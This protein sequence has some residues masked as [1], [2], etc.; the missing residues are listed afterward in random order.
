MAVPVSIPKLGNRMRAGLVAEWY[1]PDGAVVHSGD[2]VCRLECDFVT[3]DLEAEGSGVLRHRLDAGL[4]R[5]PGDLLGV[6]LAQGERLPDFEPVD[7]EAFL[8]EPEPETPP[9]DG[10]APAPV[11]AAHGGRW[12]SP[13]AAM[14]TDWEAPA[15]EPADVEPAFV[16][17][18]E[19]EPSAEPALTDPL[20]FPRRPHFELRP[21][22]TGL[23]D[24]VPGDA[25]EFES[26]LLPVPRDAIL[27]SHVEPQSMVHDAEDSESMDLADWLKREPENPAPLLDA[28]ASNPIAPGWTR[29]DAGEDAA[30]PVAP[31]AAALTMSATVA[32]T[33]AHKMC[34]QLAREWRAAEI[35]P[36]ADDIVLRAVARAL[37][38]LPALAHEAPLALRTLH[39]GEDAIRVL[40]NAA[41]RPF[42]DAVATLASGGDTGAP[43]AVLTSCAADGIEAATPRL[44][45]GHPLALALG[46]ERQAP[47]WN[48]EHWLPG[49]V[50][51]LTIAY[52]PAAIADAEAARFLARVR[53]LVESPYALLAD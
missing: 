42:R 35:R 22:T 19:P 25:A 27:E 12:N 23:W 1:Q 46:A 20:P 44:D 39:D 18:P 14:P 36:A 43:I 4:V 37:R 38:D 24:P 17:E 2:P 7:L 5:P 3:V 40:A 28:P 33:E 16:P 52:D 41:T 29:W 49:P 8:P 34:E 48:G 32:L 21:Q 26:E 50:S 6:I 53:D 30:A 31:A 9:A 11:P 47:T 45:G 13:A 51:T 10:L 15:G